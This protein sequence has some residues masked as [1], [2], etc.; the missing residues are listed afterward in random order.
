MCHRDICFWK[1]IICCLFWGFC[2]FFFHTISA[3]TFFTDDLKTKAVRKQGDHIAT[4]QVFGFIFLQ[5]NKLF[6]FSGFVKGWIDMKLS[7]KRDNLSTSYRWLMNVISNQ[8]MVII[9]TICWYACTVE[10][11]SWRESFFN[12]WWFIQEKRQ[13][14]WWHFTSKPQWQ[15]TVFLWVYWWLG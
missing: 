11:L 12:L 14:S 4:V 13:A 7:D 1:N 5:A 3:Q 2:L 6:L 15:Q 8:Q 10:N 9:S